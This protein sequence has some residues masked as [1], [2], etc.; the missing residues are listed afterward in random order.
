MYAAARENARFRPISWCPSLRPRRIDRLRLVGPPARD[1]STFPSAIGVRGAPAPPVAEAA[2]KVRLPAD[3]R[4]TAEALELRIDPK[5]DRFSGSVDIAI[6]LDQPRSVVW[7]HGKGFNVS[8]AAAVLDGGAE[9]AGTWRQEGD[10]GLASLTFPRALPAGKAKLHVDYDAPFGLK[11][12]GLYKVKQEGSAYAFTQFESTAA[13]DAFPC[14]DEP[15]FKIPFDTT[16][17]V[18]ADAQA[19]SNTKEIERRTD[20]GSLRV[21]FAPTLP[22]PSYLLAFAV[23]PLEI[24]P[25]ADVAPNAVRKRPL[26]LRAVTAKGH[27]KEV[28]Y[29]IAHTGDFVTLLEQFFGIEYPY[30]KLDILA[31]PDKHGAME[32]A[33]AI[34]FGDQFLLFDEKTAPVSQKRVY[35]NV[36]LHE[37]A[38]QWVGDLVTAAWW[39]DIWLNEA[40]ATW[41]QGELVDVWDPKME[42]RMS[43]LERT[44]SAIGNDV[45]VSARA[46]RQPIASTNDIKNAFD[47]ITYEKGA[48]VIGMFERWVGPETFQR[49]VHDYLAA[50]RLGSATADDFLGAESAASGKD[51]KTPFHTFLDQ[52]GVPFVE[53]EVKCDGAP[54]LHLKQSRYLPLG[55]T[56]DA[57]RSW[58][59]PLCAKYQVGK[60]TK[61][62]RARCSP[63]GKGILPLGA[64]SPRLGPSERRIGRVLPLRA[65]PRRPREAAGEGVRE[66]ELAR[67][68]RLRQQP[69]RRVRPR[70]PLVRGRAEGGLRPGGGSPRQHCPR[71]DGLH[72]PG[73]RLALRRRDP[74]LHRELRA[75]ALPRRVREARMAA[76][77]ERR[78]GSLRASVTGPPVSHGHGARSRGPS[79]GE[80]ARARLPWVQEGRRPPPRRARPEPGRDRARRPG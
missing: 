55:S 8:R 30:D 80:E 69:P 68:R 19:V 54:R 22:L 38:H 23:G 37:L 61:E 65:R 44:Q 39:D 20:G 58:Q 45:L 24:V 40:F 27:G 43:L 51:V 46:I 17:V 56:G 72:R 13:R 6:S 75:N 79:R 1:P 77:E 15:G 11:L 10:D 4:P 64:A 31:L 73:A 14:F 28:A 7:L 25:A 12:E 59:I 5:Q 52:P 47:G 33:G 29:A 26:P 9:V 48:A 16:L 34:T 35:A 18:P 67:S 60:E 50:H 42:A 57:N 76:G 3:V 36:M 70:R 32:N 53:A 71:S 63:T 74:P 2:P 78:P 41:M 62:K 49:G 66:L 21:H